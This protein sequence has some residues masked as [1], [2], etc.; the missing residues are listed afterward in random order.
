MAMDKRFSKKTII[1]LISLLLIFSL[2]SCQVDQTCTENTQE[3]VV[4]IDA[5]DESNSTEKNNHTSDM[6]SSQISA[7]DGSIESEKSEI[8]DEK[9]K[10]KYLLTEKICEDPRTG[11]SYIALEKDYDDQGRLLELQGYNE[12]GKLTDYEKYTYDENGN[13]LKLTELRQVGASKI[14]IT[15]TFTYEDGR[16][17]SYLDRTSVGAKCGKGRFKYYDSGQLEYEYRQNIHQGRITEIYYNRQG[18]KTRKI[19][20]SSILDITLESSYEREYDDEGKLIKETEIKTVAETGRVTKE[21]NI[22]NNNGKLTESILT[23]DDSGV[24]RCYSWEY[25]DNGNR[26]RFIAEF[27]KGDKDVEEYEFDEDGNKIKEIHKSVL[28]NRSR[29]VGW[30]EYDYN[31]NGK[32]Q[33]FIVKNSKGKTISIN[34]YEYEIY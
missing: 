27:D 8:E 20:S 1:V 24:I 13:V 22:Y 34:K 33:N 6:N 16:K 12:E 11:E 30:Y 17:K 21:T 2:L 4:K 9:E 15:R 31:D 25:D 19:D 10:D 3:S 5:E 29:V 26:I 28:D 18:E 23:N 7:N 32:L 14:E